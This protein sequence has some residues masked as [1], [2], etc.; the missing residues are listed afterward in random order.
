MKRWYQHRFHNVAALNIVFSTMRWTPRFAQP[1]M[2]AVTALI[3]F[4]L[5]FLFAIF[6]TLV[7][8]VTMILVLFPFCFCS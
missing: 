2:A 3:F 5:Q 8:L 4:L 1:P 6:V 7:V